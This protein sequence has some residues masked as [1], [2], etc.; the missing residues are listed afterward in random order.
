MIESALMA[1]SDS[2]RHLLRLTPS[3]AL[4]PHAHEAQD[5]SLDLRTILAAFTSDEAEGLF[6]LA[7]L[8]GGGLP[9]ELAWWREFAA[10]YLTERC[11]TPEGESRLERIDAPPVDALAAL[12]AGAPPMEGAEYLT[13]GVLSALWKR[14]DDWLCAKAA[15]VGGLEPFLADGRDA[16]VF[17][18]HDERGAT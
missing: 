17:F 6:E 18:R 5:L 16:Y 8:P 1:V 10:L 2:D 15:A 7:A 4:R 12:A 9:P 14:L 13:T 11:H 3:G